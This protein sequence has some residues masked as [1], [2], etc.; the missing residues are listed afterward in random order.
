MF[1]GLFHLL[2]WS[3]FC[4]QNVYLPQINLLSLYYGL[5]LNSFLCKAKNLVPGTH[6]RPGKWPSSHAPHSF[7][8]QLNQLKQYLSWCPACPS[9]WSQSLL[10]QYLLRNWET[11]GLV[12]SGLRDFILFKNRM[13]WSLYEKNY[14]WRGV[15]GQLCQL[16]QWPMTDYMA[17]ESLGGEMLSLQFNKT[18]FQ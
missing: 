15:L 8:Q 11:N 16:P 6:L 10:F 5:F 17:Q 9:P 14:S 13:S 3:T 4:L 2:R 1:P 18:V 12:F 7:L